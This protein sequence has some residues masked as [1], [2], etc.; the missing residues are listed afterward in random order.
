MSIDNETVQ[1]LAYE[2]SFQAAAKYISTLNGMLT[3]L[4]QL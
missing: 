1:M 2:Q 4:M 3:T